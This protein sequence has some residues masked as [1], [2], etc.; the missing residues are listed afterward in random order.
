MAR[1]KNSRILGVTRPDLQNNSS[2]ERFKKFY[3][4][5]QSITF[6]AKVENCEIIDVLSQV[7]LLYQG[8][9]ILNT[10]QLRTVVDYTIDR[11]NGEVM[12]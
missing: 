5:K 7:S 2:A 8:C 12:G 3:E 1:N 6:I 10:E 9:E 4:Q 11:V